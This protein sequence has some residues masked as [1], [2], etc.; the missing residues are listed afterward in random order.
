MSNKIEAIFFDLGETLINFGQ[1]HVNLLFDAGARLAYDY[2][3]K[4]GQPLPPLAI[5]RRKQSWAIKLTVLKS[6]LTRREFN[7]LD[8]L[9][10]TSSKLGQVL[11]RCQLLKLAGMF[12]EPLRQQAVVEDGVPNML[13]RFADDGLKLGIISNTFVP[14]EV[15]DEHLAAEGLLDFFQTRIYSCNVGRRKPHPRIFAEAVR[16][17]GLNPARTL[18]VG[19]LLRQDVFGGNQAGMISVL[20]DPVDRHVGARIRP[21]HTIRGLLELT[22]LVARYNGPSRVAGQTKF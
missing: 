3:K 19:D 20:K 21:R 6:K 16:Q 11:T 14:G 7:S 18:F 1:I 17:A 5:Y 10:E 4:L 9:A 2:L 15:L 12:Y 13:R 22:E 8:L